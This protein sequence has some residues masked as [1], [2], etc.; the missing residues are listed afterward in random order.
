[1]CVCVR[2]HVC[3]CNAMVV[4]QFISMY[5]ISFTSLIF[6]LWIFNSLLKILKVRKVSVICNIIISITLLFFV[7]RHISICYPI[8]SSWKTF[9]NISWQWILLAFVKKPLFCLHFW[10]VFSLDT[11]R[12]AYWVFFQYFKDISWF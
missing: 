6:F 7:Y 11:E 2:T 1:M 8:P 10:K 12:W 9:F 3:V 5:V 4:I